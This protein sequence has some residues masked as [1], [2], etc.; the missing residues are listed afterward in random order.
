MRLYELTSRLQ[1]GSEAGGFFRLSHLL[2]WR[3]RVTAEDE[4]WILL[5]LL[6]DRTVFCSRGG[7]GSL[8][9]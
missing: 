6:F 8:Y 4:E 5:G 7:R 3:L 2:W 1:R 9:I